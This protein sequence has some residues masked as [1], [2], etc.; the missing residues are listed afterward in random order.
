MSNSYLIVVDMQ[1]DFIDGAL[2]T[3]EAQAIVEA[4]A[5][6]A[7]SFDGTVVF[8]KDTHGSDYA[9]TQEGRNLPIPHCI[10]GTTGWELAPTLETIR[11]RRSAPV[12]EKPT[13]GSLDL[14]RWLVAQ[15]NAAPI[16]SIELCGLC[17]DICVVSNALTIKAHLPEVPPGE[18]A[19]CRRHRRARRRD[20]HYGE[21]PGAN[22]ATA[23]PVLRRPFADDPPETGPMPTPGPPA[24]SRPRDW[25]RSCILANYRANAAAYCLNAGIAACAAVATSIETAADPQPNAHRSATSATSWLY[26]CSSTMSSYQTFNMVN[27]SHQLA[28]LRSSRPACSVHG[29]CGPCTETDLMA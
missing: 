2:G 18:S 28:R 3:P 8:T 21:L 19:L 29:T 22:P 14:A 24:A 13:F 4:V 11:A 6:R 7:S 25:R 10:T 1:N 20:R 15:N 5:Q 23:L 17:T 27:L 9:A 26:R 16:D 12:F